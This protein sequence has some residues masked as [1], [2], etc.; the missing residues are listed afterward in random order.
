MNWNTADRQREHDAADVSLSL[1][2]GDEY[3]M[4][5]SSSDMLNVRSDYILAF[6]EDGCTAPQYRD[7]IGKGNLASYA[8]T[9]RKLD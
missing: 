3:A 8:R 9:I 7:R 2:F 4:L 6:R 1:V 5:P